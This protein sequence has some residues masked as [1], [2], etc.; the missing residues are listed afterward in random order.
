MKDDRIKKAWDNIEPDPEA[1][2]R[3]LNNILAAKQEMNRPPLRASRRIWGTA[4]SGIIAAALLLVTIRIIWPIRP[5]TPGNT[6]RNDAVSNLHLN[7]TLF[8]NV[9]GP[10]SAG[11]TDPKSEEPSGWL[12]STYGSKDVDPLSSIPSALHRDEDGYEHK[13]TAPAEGI[14][15]PVEPGATEGET[16][17]LSILTNPD[18]LSLIEYANRD[19]QLLAIAVAAN[20]AEL[21]SL[22][23]NFSTLLS[24]ETYTV[25]DGDVTGV[26]YFV[27]ATES[28]QYSFSLFSVKITD[29]ISTK[30]SSGS[31]VDG[32]AVGRTVDIIVP[33][34]ID[35]DRADYTNPTNRVGSLSEQIRRGS[36]AGFLLYPNDLTSLGESFIS[37]LYRAGLDPE[38]GYGVL[39]VETDNTFHINSGLQTDFTALNADDFIAELR[40]KIDLAAD[41]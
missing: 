36:R 20:P 35:S 31:A 33:D 8:G 27:A 12:E 2:E 3:M 17:P 25:I 10:Y 11:Q 19:A 22:D 34:D 37:L 21:P 14:S 18:G 32:L 24:T 29:V 41:K 6:P 7:E 26:R 30:N 23:Y 9:T 15:V 16:S 5:S 13:G 38:Y 4:L 1:K 28:K 40:D 39:F